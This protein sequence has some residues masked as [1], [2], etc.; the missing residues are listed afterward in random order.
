MVL[1][2][3]TA[4]S[5]VIH[6]ACCL[7]QIPILV[8]LSRASAHERLAVRRGAPGA[9]VLLW[10]DRHV[11]LGEAGSAAAAPVADGAHCADHQVSAA[12]HVWRLGD[13]CASEGGSFLMRIYMLLSSWRAA[14]A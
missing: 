3:P 11:P 1:H 12:G 6:D 8:S 4:G 14:D 13:A 9:R 10:A 5:W 7:L 2:M